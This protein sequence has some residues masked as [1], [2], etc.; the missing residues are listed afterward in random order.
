MNSVSHEATQQV[1]NQLNKFYEHLYSKKSNISKKIE[2]YNGGSISTLNLTF[3][4]NLL[5]NSLLVVGLFFWL[6]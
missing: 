6:I 3:I 5:F 1:E 2:N 4:N